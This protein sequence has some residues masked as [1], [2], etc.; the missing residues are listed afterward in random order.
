MINYKKIRE[1]ISNY[2]NSLTEEDIAN[3]RREYDNMPDNSFYETPEG[4][5]LLFDEYTGGKYTQFILTDY[6]ISK[7]NTD[8]NY[9]HSQ[10]T[11]KQNR[12]NSL[13]ISDSNYR[14]SRNT[15]NCKATMDHPLDDAA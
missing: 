12:G 2:F 1:G 14:P 8:S 13:L 11:S 15:M 5:E 9:R 6:A 4:M 3:L 10:K 7:I